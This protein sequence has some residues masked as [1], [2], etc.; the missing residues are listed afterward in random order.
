[1]EK[2]ILNECQTPIE[3]LELEKLPKEIQDQFWDFFWNIPFIQ[4]LT[5]KDRPRAKDLP[6]DGEGKIIIDI[7]KLHILEDMEYMMPAG[8]HYSETGK[9]TDLRPNHNPNS[10]YVKWV[11]EEVRRCLDGYVRPSDGE[12]IPGDL[13]YCWNYSVMSVYKKVIRCDKKPLTLIY[14][15]SL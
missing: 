8:K 15:P 10:E 2:I 13:Y 11:R 3:D 5:S 7:T 4:N 1:M 14:F 12:W 9:Y 6:R